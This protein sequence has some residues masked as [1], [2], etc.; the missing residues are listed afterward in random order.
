MW[1]T[2]YFRYNYV[3]VL[4]VSKVAKV[5]PAARDPVDSLVSTGP[6]VSEVAPVMVA[7]QGLKV[8]PFL[9]STWL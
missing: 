8:H 3:P 4:C 6:R 5:N 1:K 9:F 2:G 7:K